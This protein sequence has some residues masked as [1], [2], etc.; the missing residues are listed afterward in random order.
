MGRQ[1]ICPPVFSGPAVTRSLGLPTADGQIALNTKMTVMTE[2]G[3]R[4]IHHSSVSL[5][6]KRVACHAW[7]R[8][9]SMLACCDGGPEVHIF[10]VS[11][12]HDGPADL[13]HIARLREHNQRVCSMEWASSGLLVTCSHD[14]TSY[15]WKEVCNQICRIMPFYTIFV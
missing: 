9:L 7:R 2:S 8:D 5:P 1:D 15:V 13:R 12:Q 6:F 14:R 10:A 3:R 11:I 4:L